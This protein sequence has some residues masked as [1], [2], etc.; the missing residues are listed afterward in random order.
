MK[1]ERK[2][3]QNQINYVQSHKSKDDGLNLGMDHLLSRYESFKQDA[4][5]IFHIT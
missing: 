5:P 4:K 1:N 3:E 2:L